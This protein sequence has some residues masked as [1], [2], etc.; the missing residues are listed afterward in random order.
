MRKLIPVVISAALLAVVSLAVAAPGAAADTQASSPSASA[1]VVRVDR[2]VPAR[3]KV[4]HRRF[5]P[6]AHPSPRG[7]RQIIRAEALRWH[8]SATSLARRVQCESRFHWWAGNGS[9]QGVLQFAW[10][11]F[12]RGLRTIRDRRVVIRT[13]RVR[14]VREV[15]IAHYSDGHTETK[16]GPAHRQRI[17]YVYTGRLPRR[18]SVSHAWAQLRIGAQAIRGISAVRSSE[19]SCGA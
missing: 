16:P 12:N 7:V 3:R 5:R 8:I 14:R 6:W 15:R 11:T 4:I 18:P 13:E 2:V 17:V 10:G 19:W 9:F 1:S